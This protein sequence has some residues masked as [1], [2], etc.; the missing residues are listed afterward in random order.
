MIRKL[1]ALTL[2]GIVGFVVVAAISVSAQ[3]TP[4]YSHAAQARFIPKEL[5]RVYLGI[6]LRDLAKIYDLSKAE[7]EDDRFEA[8]SIW[9]PLDKGNVTGFRIDVQGFDMEL[10]ETALRPDTVKRKGSEPGDIYESEIK[11]PIVDKIPAKAFVYAFYV[12]FK[13]EFDLR[14]FVVKT[15][16]KGNVR[17]PDDE[18]HF[19]DIEWTKKTS[20]SLLW[21]I[22]SFHEGDD[23]QLQLLGRIKG[24]EWSID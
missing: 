8:L 9:I 10:R 5:G 19:Y 22:R 2:I 7:I 21:L 23:R 4:K 3:K 12:T 16:G 18:Y 1:S 24:T 17:K 13:K 15:Y 20:D 14:S 6:P 11:R